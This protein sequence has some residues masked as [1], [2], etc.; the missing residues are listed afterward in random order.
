MMTSYARRGDALNAYRS[1]AETVS[2]ARA[3]VMLYD[4]AMRRL[5]EAAQ[6]IRDRR[7]EDR[8]NAVM[9]AY[10][11]VNGLHCQL[12]FDAGGEI[13]EVL[14]RYYLYILERMLQINI[15][16]DPA[17][18]EELVERLR[19]MRASWAAIADG[20]GPQASAVQ[21]PPRPVGAAFST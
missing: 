19:E 15:K 1:A 12:D 5:G 6:A 10:A 11:I 20:A 21:N 3:I 7:I 4:G 17:I 9:K 2:P 18:C 14:D 16:N 8:Y 13:A